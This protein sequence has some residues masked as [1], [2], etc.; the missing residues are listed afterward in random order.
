MNTTYKKSNKCV[1]CDTE[2]KQTKRDGKFLCYNCAHDYEN[3]IN[4]LLIT[5]SKYKDKIQNVSVYTYSSYGTSN[6]TT[7]IKVLVNKNIYSHAYI[8][9]PTH[10]ILETMEL[11]DDNLLL[12]YIDAEIHTQY[13]YIIKQYKEKAIKD[14]EGILNNKNFEKHCLEH[15][16]TVAEGYEKFKT[17]FLS[18][19]DN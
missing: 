7:T 16:M 2:I 6:K 12:E 18:S 4:D 5:S 19:Y 17:N 9:I 8:K 15:G 10:K 1:F 14:T 3:K 11:N 13:L